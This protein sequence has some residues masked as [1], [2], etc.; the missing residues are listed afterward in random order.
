MSAN[1][2]WNANAFITTSVTTRIRNVRVGDVY[3]GFA[4]YG[5]A[6]HNSNPNFY[7]VDL[8]TGVETLLGNAGTLTGGGSFVVWTVLERGGYLY[9]QT[10]DNGIQVYNMNSATSL[11]S[12]YTTYTKL[13]LDAITGGSAWW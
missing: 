9:V 10:T 5:D 8:A 3:S 11:G 4:Y 12:L 13:D 2:A 7:A 1:T 6:G